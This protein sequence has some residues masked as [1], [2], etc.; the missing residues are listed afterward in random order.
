ML[1]EFN[2][3]WFTGDVPT[4]LL[5]E[6]EREMLT[7]V[8]GEL[9]RR[10]I[11]SIVGLRRVGKTVM[12]YQIIN[13]LLDGGVEPTNIVYFSFDERVDELAD[14]LDTYRDV[15]AVDFRD[16][17]TYIL[18]D[19][20]QK[21]ENWQNQIKKYYDLYPRIKFIISGSESLFIRQRTK[22]TLAGRIRE[23]FLSTLSFEEFLEMK[24]VEPKPYG[25]KIK[26]RFVEYVNKGGFPETVQESLKEARRYIRSSVVDKILFKDIVQMSSIRDPDL[27]RKIVEVLAVNPGMYVN[28]K[29]LAQQLG[30]DRRTISHYILW[31]KES[32][33]IRLLR[34]YRKGRVAMLRK[35]RRAYLVDTGIVTAYKP[36]ID[37]TF[38]G[39]LVETLVVNSLNAETFWRNRH[40]VDC[41]VQGVPIEVKYR[42]RITGADLRGVRAFMKR[43]KSKRGVVVTKDEEKTEKVNEG[44]IKLIPA[45]KFALNPS[46]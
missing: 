18:L 8:L 6:Y 35:N 37:D 27:L 25:P 15:Q 30:R 14:V 4:D 42:E 29:S 13:H 38:F 12:M 7:K 23:Y 32:F 43:F 9:R 34:N 21:L 2:E 10:Q 22:E 17:R 5:E 44:V 11:V 39:R 41:V 26:P 20:I 3:W 45:W 31:L 19:E 1:E 33:L 28:Y 46:A 24:G 36:V 16:G 40:E